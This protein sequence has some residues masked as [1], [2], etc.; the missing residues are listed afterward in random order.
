M[1]LQAPMERQTSVLS[2]PRHIDYVVSAEFAQRNQ[3][4]LGYQP[5]KIG[6]RTSPF[7]VTF[8]P[9]TTSARVDPLDPLDP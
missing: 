9:S 5:G 7:D 2:D 8:V 3:N 4:E 1:A 6:T